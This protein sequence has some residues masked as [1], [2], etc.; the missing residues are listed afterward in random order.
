MQ[1]YNPFET[2]IIEKIMITVAVII[3]LALFGFVAYAFLS[4]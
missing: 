4:I 3:L 1:D 2:D